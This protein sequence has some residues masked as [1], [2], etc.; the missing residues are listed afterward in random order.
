M[1][2]ILGPELFFWIGFLPIEMQ[3]SSTLEGSLIQILNRF[4]RQCLR[5]GTLSQRLYYYLFLKRNVMHFKIIGDSAAI[6]F[7]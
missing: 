5:N 3:F 2:K 1:I 6:I 7:R 4:S